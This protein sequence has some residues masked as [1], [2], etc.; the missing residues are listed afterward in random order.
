VRR[1]DIKVG[2]RV[3]HQLPGGGDGKHLGA[4]CRING[5][6]VTIIDI[7]SADGTKTLATP[8]EIKPA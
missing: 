4:V 5:P 3:R 6:T 2:M 8:G 7:D 1:R